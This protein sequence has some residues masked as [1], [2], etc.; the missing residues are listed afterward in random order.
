[1]DQKEVNAIQRKQNLSYRAKIEAVKRAREAKENGGIKD[2][3]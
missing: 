3:N 2:N 1:M